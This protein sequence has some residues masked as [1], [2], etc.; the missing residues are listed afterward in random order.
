MTESEYK[1]PI[2]VGIM[3]GS[4][5]DLD[6]MEPA[7][8][9]LKDYEIPFASTVASG[10]RTE[11]K[12]KRTAKEW[13]KRGC[14]VIIAGAGLA[15]HLAGVLSSVTTLPIIG[16]PLCSAKSTLGGLD[17]LLSTVQMPPEIPVLTV[18]INRAE[19]AAIGAIQILA[20]NNERLAQLLKNNRRVLVAKVDQAAEELADKH[21][22]PR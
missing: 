3:L 21:G 2:D 5:S 14:K 7:R 1:N 8:R 20:L 13:E 10:H 11:E 18:G 19:N 16:V 4:G 12:V 15:A 9:K 6:L 22:W 17:S